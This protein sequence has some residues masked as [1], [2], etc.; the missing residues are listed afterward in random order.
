MSTTADAAN[1]VTSSAVMPYSSD[2]STPLPSATIDQPGDESGDRRAQSLEEQQPADLTAVGAEREPQSDLATALA[3]DDTER[4][5]QPDRRE[6]ERDDGERG[7]QLR[8]N[9]A[10]AG[11]GAD[12][13][14][15]GAHVGQRLR[16]IDLA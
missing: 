14:V 16:R 1:V 9:P 8:R 13:V 5:V 15:V 4:A 11:G 12:D 2:R 7:Q 6:H 3:G 10:R